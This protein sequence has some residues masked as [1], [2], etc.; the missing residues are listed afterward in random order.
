MAKQQR[1]QVQKD[2]NRPKRPITPWLAFCNEKRGEV[3]KQGMSITVVT[4]TLS[5]MWSELSETQK[6]PYV[7]VSTKDRE[8]YTEAMKSY[9][10]P[11][12]VPAEVV[13]NEA[14]A[15]A[16]VSEEAVVAPV[17]PKVKKDRK[18]TGYL[19]YCNTMRPT[20]KENNSGAKSTELMKLVANSWKELTDE[21]RTEWNEKARC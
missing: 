2:T 19:L 20:F 1:K 3:S 8:R 15:P 4:Q 11:Q 6:Q 10:P 17:V 16:D 5:K 14:V 12:P 9:V 7:D 18:P 21:Q 13:P